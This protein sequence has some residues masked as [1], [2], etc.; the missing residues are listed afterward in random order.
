MGK[1]PK[2]WRGLSGGQQQALGQKLYLAGGGENGGEEALKA[3]LDG[4]YEIILRD[5]SKTLVDQYGRC[6]PPSGLK[7]GQVVDAN[8]QYRLVQPEIDYNTVLA[9]ITQYFP[10]MK[11]ISA[12]EFK[13][14]VEALL[15]KLDDQKQ[16]K[17]LR[18]G[19]WLPI[20]LPQLAVTDYGRTLEEIFLAAVERSYTAQFPG[21]RFY[22]YRKG[23]LAGQV[24]VVEQSRHQQLIDAMRQ[25]P[26]VCILFPAA[27]QGFG[28]EADRQMIEEFPQGFALSGAIDTAMAHVVYAEVLARDYQVPV[29]DCAANTWQGPDHSLYFDSSDGKRC[30]G[31]RNLSAGEGYSGGVVLFECVHRTLGN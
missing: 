11:F 25:G 10:E 21:R 8:R 24:S 2:I 28:I 9:R 31:R 14:R 3:L 23:D 22:N 6:I 13:Q 17:N 7:K 26:V 30:F 16:V 27:L 29:N 18:R 4:D 1:F 5:A 12:T 15:A 20:V 19:V